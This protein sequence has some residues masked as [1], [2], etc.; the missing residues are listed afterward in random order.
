MVFGTYE[1]LRIPVGVERMVS[2]A[3]KLPCTRCR[4][5]VTRLPDL[6]LPENHPKRCFIRRAVESEMR[7]SY[8]DRILKT[9]PEPMQNDES[10][11]ANQPP[12]PEAEYEDPC[13][14]SSF[15]LG[16]RSNLFTANPHHE[17]SESILSLLRGRS[18]AEEVIAHLD[19][20]KS[21]LDVA[22]HPYTHI[23][24]FIRSLAFQSLLSIGSRSFSHLLNAI[25]R[26]L[27]LLRVLAPTGDT[28]A[29]RDILAT[30]ASFWKRNRHMVGIVFDKLMQYQIVDPTDV[31][32]WIFSTLA[33]RDDRG[34]PLYIQTSEWELLK[35][36][37]DKANG[38]V[39]VARKKVAALRKEH[40]DNIARAKARGGADAG[41][42]EVDGEMKPL[43]QGEKNIALSDC[44]F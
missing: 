23:D 21:T 20:L 22:P 41:N 36:T 12:G 6:G 30:T 17:L 33:T 32:A 43:N 40:D 29:K 35:G 38:R 44:A 4:F 11:I 16:I 18:R 28:E 39:T 19:Y 5:V 9:L 25:E 34:G 14:S 3:S 37:L 7:L 13:L 24:S 2:D 42:M 8:H 10:V 1:Q 26:Y 15:E 31:V 27:P